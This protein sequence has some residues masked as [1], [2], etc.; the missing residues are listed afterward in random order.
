AARGWH[1]KG[2]VGVGERSREE[3]GAVGRRH[4]RS[5]GEATR[6]GLG[7]V[8]SVGLE[9]GRGEVVEGCR[10]VV[11]VQGVVVVGQRGRH[12]RRLP[13][14]GTRAEMRDQSHPQGVGGVQALH[15]AQIPACAPEVPNKSLTRLL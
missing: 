9:Q 15:G 3:G 10:P 13:L 4:F 1:P 6:R 2:R 5:G 12:G 7:G 8:E 11:R 14:R